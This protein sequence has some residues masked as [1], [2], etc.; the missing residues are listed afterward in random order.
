M[1]RCYIKSVDLRADG[2]AVPVVDDIATVELDLWAR[3]R[4][5]A[6]VSPNLLGF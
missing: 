5:L 6:K 4:G 1:C 3:E 2:D